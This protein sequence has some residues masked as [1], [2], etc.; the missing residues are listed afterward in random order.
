MFLSGTMDQQYVRSGTASSVWPRVYSDSA[1]AQ[2]L[3]DSA[4]AIRSAMILP[5]SRGR[6]FQKRYTRLYYLLVPHLPL[7]LLLFLIHP[8]A[9]HL[10]SSPKSL[11][12]LHF[13]DSPLVQAFNHRH[14]TLQ[15]LAGDSL[16]P[17]RH[18]RLQQ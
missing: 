12:F 1:T 4:V 16:G 17:R 2:C 7:L 9:S 18:W 14:G 6:A 3:S 8:S 5:S 13:I 11:A 15:S 10:R